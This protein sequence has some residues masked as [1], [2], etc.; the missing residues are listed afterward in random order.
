MK[1][2]DLIMNFNIIYVKQNISQASNKP[3]VAT[4][5]TI[6]LAVIKSFFNIKFLP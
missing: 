6:E 4:L 3:V 2:I 5:P 1:Y